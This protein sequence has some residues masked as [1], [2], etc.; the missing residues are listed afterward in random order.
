MQ[1][2]ARASTTRLQ[3]RIEGIEHVPARGPAIL[4][5]R[6]F[7]YLYDGA[8]LMAALRRPV[9]FVVALDW[10]H[11]RGRQLMEVL[12]EWAEWPT[13]LRA[14]APTQG[15]RTPPDTPA[16]RRRY[17]RVALLRCTQVLARGE[18]LAIFPQGSPTI[19]PL[20]PRNAT[21]GWLP[22]AGGYLTVAERARRLGLAVPLIPTGFSY[23]GQAERPAS[24]TLRFGVPERI[25]SACERSATGARLEA[26]VRVLS[27]EA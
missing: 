14:A 4:V 10:A 20:A 9:R 7:H 23:R 1:A 5:C 6:H 15:L 18:L 11:G 25:A 3:V 13:V 26:R 19:D 17:A 16:E 27:A 8:I 2:L 24:V 21:A 12:C 22:F